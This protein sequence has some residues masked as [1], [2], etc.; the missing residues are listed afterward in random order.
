MGKACSASFMTPSFRVVVGTLLLVLVVVVNHSHHG[1]ASPS[2]SAARWSGRC[3]W[4]R[5]APRR[6]RGRFGTGYGGGL[7]TLEAS[8]ASLRSSGFFEQV[9]GG[10]GGG[11]GGR[12][13]EPGGS[14]DDDDEGHGH[15]EASSCTPPR[16]RT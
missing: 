15:G 5:T 6:R 4:S 12:V 13:G 1:A 9:R 10:G 8:L 7:A 11:G 3:A 14:G 2:P 16:G